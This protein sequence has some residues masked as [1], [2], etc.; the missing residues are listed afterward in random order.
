MAAAAATLRED[1]EKNN[2]NKSRKG[3][4][5]AKVSSWEKEV[6]ESA[7]THGGKLEATARRARVFL[8]TQK[9]SM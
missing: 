4:T 2:K 8:H 3:N 9:H 7:G 1:S 5:R 6:R